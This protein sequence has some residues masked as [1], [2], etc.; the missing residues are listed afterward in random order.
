M[1][2]DPALEGW[3]APY[4]TNLFFLLFFS[5]LPLPQ[6]VSM[7]ATPPSLLVAGP[8]SST[9][10]WVASPAEGQLQN[11]P[12]SSLPE[13]DSPTTTAAPFSPATPVVEGSHK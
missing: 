7:C 8:V 12:G 5:L 9:K 1:R 10:L 2:E 11:L 3:D 4:P 13:C 6:K